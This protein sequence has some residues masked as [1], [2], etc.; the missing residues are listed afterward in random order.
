[1]KILLVRLRLVGDVVF[2]TP[3]VRAIR[4]RFPH[5]H[6]TYL[7]EHGAAAV[8]A[9]SPHVDQLIVAAR[10]RGWRRF[11]DDLQLVRQL[12][13]RR[14]DV[15]ID[16]HGGPRSSWLAWASGAPRRIGYAVRGRTW[17]YSER[18]SRPRELRSRH[19]VE[20]QWDLL[21]PL[22]IPA[23]DPARDSVQMADDGAARARTDVKLASAGV[24]PEHDLLVFHVSAGNPF[25]RWPAPSFAETAAHLV[26]DHPHRRVVFTSGP[27]DL[28]AATAIAE[29]TR[30]RL[31]PG[32][33]DRVVNCEE[34][35][36]PELRSLI[37]R[38]ALFIGGDS[39]PLH[40]AATTDTPI[41]GLYGPTLAARSAPWRAPELVSEAVEP[42]PLPCRP[43][44]QRR[45]E[46]GDFRCLTSLRPEAV[47]AAA[48]RALAR[49]RA[50]ADNQHA[51][52]KAAAR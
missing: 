30:A 43:C 2:T 47:I 13:R 41:V 34:F 35:D 3:A 26:G 45:C 15:V 28:T 18:I 32:A 21:R 14:F 6:I 27:S 5:A 49:A 22:D 42:G 44:D 51:F 9:G 29:A 17:M 24:G 37:Q 33:A 36:L 25:R 12:R 31:G 7:V 19:S 46:P 11:T 16:F 52:P 38:A 50:S 48:E 10:R 39:G 40:I 20:N 23:P 1:M 4:R 8:L